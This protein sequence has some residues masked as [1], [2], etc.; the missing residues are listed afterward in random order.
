MQPSAEWYYRDDGGEQVELIDT[1]WAR[2]FCADADDQGYVIWNH[3]SDSLSKALDPLIDRNRKIIWRA[4]GSG[5]ATMVDSRWAL[6]AAHLVTNSS[7]GFPIDVTNVKWCTME[8]LQENTTGGYEAECFDTDLITPN[9]TYGVNPGPVTDYAVVKLSAAPGVGWFAISQA[10]DSTISS[11]SDYTAGYPR[12]TLGCGTNTGAP[13]VDTDYGGSHL[14]VAVGDIQ[15]T[16]SGQVKYDTSTALGMSGGIH[17]YCPDGPCPDGHYLTG[18][19]TNVQATTCAGLIGTNCQGN[20][21]AG[22][23]STGPK[24]SAIRSWVINNTP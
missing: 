20:S 21:C 14:Y 22:G 15:S 1:S 19:Q 17:Y 24:G 3:S 4:S 9:P 11:H 16:P 8:N 5:S 13:T 12:R 18:V 23:Y 10:D 2:C 6:T 7:T